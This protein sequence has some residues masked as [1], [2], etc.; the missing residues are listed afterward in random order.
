M[1]ISTK[2][3]LFV[4][5]IALV[6]VTA[7]A[8]LSMIE[9]AAYVDQASN[10]RAAAGLTDLERGIQEQLVSAEHTALLLAGNAGVVK[11][12]KT[13]DFDALQTTLDTLNG[14]LLMDTISITDDKG[15]VIIRQHQPDKRGDNIAEQSNVAQA[16]SGNT[17]TTIEAGQLVKL[18]CRS[19]APVLDDTG[20]VIGSVVVGYTFENQ[21]LVDELKSVHNMEFTIFQG[22]VRLATTIM[23]DGQR[24]TGS[25]LDAHITDTV[26][27]D[28]KD[29]SGMANILGMPFYTA[30][31]PLKDM[32]GNTV[33]VLFAGLPAQS[34][35]AAKTTTL[36]HVLIFIPVLLAILLILL[37]IFVRRTTGKPMRAITS[38]AQKL[39]DGDTGTAIQV[40]GH[41][42]IAQMAKAFTAVS[43]AV[44]S[45][46]RDIHTVSKTVESGRFGTRADED[47]YNGAYRSIAAGF[48]ETM[49][50]FRQYLDSLSAPVLTLDSDYTVLYMNKAG[51]TLAG[52]NP[53]QAV[54]MKCYDIFK[55][56]DCRTSRC[57]CGR[58]MAN[59]RPETGETDAH[60]SVGMDLDIEYTGTPIILNGEV[61]G[62][63]EVIV[64]QTAIRKAGSE[65]QAQADT[66]AT[67]LNEIDIAAEQV[68]SGTRQVSD[69][70]QQI[71]MGA[72]EQS[73]AIEELTTT[74]SDIASQTQQNAASANQASELTLKVK[75]E[76]EQGNERMD[77]LQAAMAEINDS[78]A[79]IS[80]IIRVI[81]DI[82]FQ[83]NILALNAAVEAARAGVHGK[84]FAVVAEEVRNLAAR[85]AA[86]AKETTALI[87]RSVAKAEAGTKIADGT[88]AALKEMVK[89][90]EQAAALVAEIAAASGEQANAI[91]QVDRGMEQMAQVVQMNSAT[92]EETAAA[93]EELSGQA[94]YLKNMVGQYTQKG[95]SSSIDTRRML[96]DNPLMTDATV[97]ETDLGK[98]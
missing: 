43:E 36:L 64:D 2:I 50:K 60:P 27:K 76:A 53:E 20:K 48:N 87:E 75:L 39:A 93:S 49:G 62:A 24:V 47:V 85:S 92:S 12:I 18:S 4:S 30:Y 26:I 25:E 44:D 21:K 90:V 13:G 42:E 45:L 16:L 28:G 46:A 22:N 5:A 11:G 35:N 29:Y 88:A 81:D 79:G 10:E 38:A 77:A 95:D 78:S 98:Y 63:F 3:L 31:T 54:G 23:K 9:N 17:Q 40:K 70:S 69:G 51:A 8:G 96:S 56:S 32:Q 52:L 19:G 41:D 68:A 57:A 67:L 74:I 72:T 71:S 91:V 83:T 80:K 89:G 14:K 15:N 37:V 94:E 84:G 59:M 34:A 82:A 55:T 6:A 61:A 65:A 66:L 86:A 1:K 73:S 33:G 58:A 97:T 7:A